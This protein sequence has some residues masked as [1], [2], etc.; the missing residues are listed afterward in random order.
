MAFETT[1]LENLWYVR[2]AGEYTVG[3]TCGETL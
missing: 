3:D 1:E 2:H